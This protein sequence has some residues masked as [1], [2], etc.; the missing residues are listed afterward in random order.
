MGKQPA[1]V[2]ATGHR[3]VDRRIGGAGAAAA[4]AEHGMVGLLTT[5]RGGAL[6]DV[7]NL[8]TTPLAQAGKD[9]LEHRGVGRPVVGERAYVGHQCQPA[10][11]VGILVC[12]VALMLHVAL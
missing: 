4:Q 8:L 10:R 3:D 7:R 2:G 11:W 6:T 5:R 1:T 12:A 9:P